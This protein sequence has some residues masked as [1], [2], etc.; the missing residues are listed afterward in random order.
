[1][2]ESTVSQA[3]ELWQLGSLLGT[4]GQRKLLIYLLP[5]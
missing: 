1:M 4:L 5:S 3:I 2:A